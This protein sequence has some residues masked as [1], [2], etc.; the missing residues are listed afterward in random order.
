M[1]T[2]KNRHIAKLFTSTKVKA[3][4]NVE[5]PEDTEVAAATIPDEAM[6]AITL[7]QAEVDPVVICIYIPLELA[8][9]LTPQD[10]YKGTTGMEMRPESL[11][12]VSDG[13]FVYEKLFNEYPFKYQDILVSNS[14]SFIKK[15][16]LYVE[17][18]SGDEMI[19]D[20]PEE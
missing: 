2:A 6:A 15:R 1:N 4:T 12:T 5:V 17:S 19:F 7:A 18:D 10:W 9:E 11:V 3:L 14:Y 8:T 13:F 16:G 20:L